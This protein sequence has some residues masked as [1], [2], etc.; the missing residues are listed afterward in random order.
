MSLSLVAGVRAQAPNKT[1]RVATRVI[2]PFVI[3]ENDQLTGFSMDLWRGIATELKV[4]DTITPQPTVKDLLAYIRAGKADLGISAISITA[5]RE[6]EFDF[7][8]PM[9]ES[10][11][12]ILVPSQGTGGNSALAQAKAFLFSAQFLQLM[13]VI[14]LLTLIPAH[15]IWFLERRHPEG[16]ISS[17]KYPEGMFQALWWAAGT[18]A[19]Q[20]D[21]MPK[22]P[23]GR[24]IALGMMFTSVLFIAYFTAATTTNLTVSQL[25][26]SIQGPDDLPGKRVATVS[27]STSE[28]YLKERHIKS[29][30]FPQIT[31]AYKALENRQVDAVVYDSPILLYYASQEGKGKVQ[32]VG[33]VFRKEA[34]G[35]VFPA[36]STLRK[37]VSAALLAL[38]ES[39]EYDKIYNKW[40][41]GET[42]E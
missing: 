26:G 18:V 20:A 24:L 16:M 38:R 42:A 9:F 19:A 2:A 41:G 37:P 14:A 3:Q 23:L 33:D 15:I 7:S 10:G 22:S 25:Q 27:S 35:I 17:K 30:G 21:E 6:R 36:N 8:Q 13:A 4:Q 29:Q 34:Y 11:L 1:I 32:V 40:F 12:Q 31:D 5:E 28:A 39:G